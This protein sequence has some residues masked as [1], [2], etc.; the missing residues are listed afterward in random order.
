M[1]IALVGTRGVPAR[2]GGFETAAEEVGRRLVARGHEV[3]VYC[4]RQSGGSD[5]PPESYL[6][7]RLVHLPA[8]RRK[9]LET[10]SHTALSAL[11]LIRHGGTDAAILFNAA[12]AMVLPIL[13]LR[14][15]P[16]ATHV[17]GL[18]WRRA[19][20]G[21]TGQRYYRLAEA[22][23]VRWSDALIADA[24]GISDYYVEEFGAATAEIAYG[25]PVLEDAGADRLAELGL[26]PGEYHLVVAR[27]EPE[28]HVDVAIE[29]YLSSGVQHP[30]V[31]V[32]SAPYPGAHQRRIEE[33]AARQPGVRLLGGVWDQDQLDQLYA[34]ALTYVHGHSVG[35]TNPSLLRAMGAG[36]A[37]IAYDVNFNRDV[38]GPDGSFFADAEQLAKRLVEMEGAPE[39]AHAAGRRLA[40]RAGAV[41]SWD[42]VAS[43]YEALCQSLVDGYSQRGRPSGRRLSTSPWRNER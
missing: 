2:Y 40:E 6:G 39:E 4:R 23:S 43:A 14:R 3:T 7:M 11:H 17:D 30:V 24:R 5:L 22:L 15:L 10:L 8:V 18:E 9:S 20:W 41:Y 42:S 28:N 12:N 35:G 25:A 33:L 19:K 13:R 38:L 36:C 29:G 16:T 27:F 31:V 21:G 34:N 37:V 26:S 32:G 1:R